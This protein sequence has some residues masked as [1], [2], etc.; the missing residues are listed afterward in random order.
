M[1]CGTPVI[2]TT[3]SSLPEVA[4]DAGLLV[5]PGDSNELASVMIDL[6]ESSGQRQVL[7][8]AGL[9][10][11]THFSWDVTASKCLEAYRAASG[12]A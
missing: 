8:E 3:S 9:V 5:T 4:G 1:A 7:R 10:R 2:T 6:T 11:A 12:H